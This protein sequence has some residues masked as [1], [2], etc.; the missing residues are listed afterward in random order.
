MDTLR[1]YE[2]E[3]DAICAACNKPYGYDADEGCP[4]LCSRITAILDKILKE[5]I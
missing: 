3:T 2:K 1:D 4:I 5:L